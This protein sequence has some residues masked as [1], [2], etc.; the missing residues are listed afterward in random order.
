MEEQKQSL[1]NNFITKNTKL[2][3]NKII[4]VSELWLNNCS[5]LD[6]SLAIL[7]NIEKLQISSKIRDKEL[8]NGYLS[9]TVNQKIN[10]AQI[11]QDISIYS[12]AKKILELSGEYSNDN[13][14]D[15]TI[16]TNW[17][18]TID[19]KIKKEKGFDPFGFSKYEEE[20]KL[21]DAKMTLLIKA[22][23]LYLIESVRRLFPQ[24]K[25][26]NKWESTQATY[27][28]TKT[29][30]RFVIF[31]DELFKLYDKIVILSPDLVEVKAIVAN[32]IN[33]GKIEF[34]QKKEEFKKQK[35]IEANYN[36]VNN[37]IVKTDKSKKIKFVKFNDS[38]T[39]N[40]KINLQKV[41]TNNIINW[42]DNKKLIDILIDNGTIQRD[43]V[44]K[45]VLEQVKEKDVLEQ[46]KED[47]IEQ[48]KEK[49]VLEQDNNISSKRVIK[50]KKSQNNDDWTTVNNKIK[51]DKNNNLTTE[52][53]KVRKQKNHNNETIIVN[54][55]I[56]K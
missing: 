47:V 31:V 34:V 1:Y 22:F 49:D 7:A 24:E 38:Q 5:L 16:G 26:P 56:R 35:K 37:P 52:N 33:L 14:I 29:S 21:I 48:V 50:T 23:R 43:V 8:Y 6:I 32:A 30:E 55:K 12:M 4:K 20:T 15:P 13:F 18:W 40:P 39:K 42:N 11:K 2:A 9:I 36:K 17:N 10:D 19:Q 44:E 46:V 25:N 28:K 41:T 3:E 54:N 51:K 45:D 53:N 27:N